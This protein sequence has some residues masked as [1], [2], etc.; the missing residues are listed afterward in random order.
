MPGGNLVRVAGRV[1]I[2][3]LAVAIFLAAKFFAT[4]QSVQH[5]TITQPGGLPGGPVLTGIEAITNGIRLTWD[6]PSGYYQVLR[7]SLNG[8]TWQAFGGRTNLVRFETIKG[9]LTNSIFTILGPSPKYAGATACAE[10]H[11]SIENTEVNTRHAHAYEVLTMAGQDKNASCLPCHTVGYGLTTGFKIVNNVV[12]TPQLKGVQCENCHSSAANHAANPDDLISRP[13]LE[14]AGQVCG[15]CHSG[16]QNPT[17]DEWK[18]SGHFQ[19]VEDM[20]DPSRIESCGRCHSGTSRLAQMAGLRGSALTNSVHGD[21]NVGITC[22]VCHEPHRVRVFTNVLNG[23]FA[24]TNSLTGRSI[25][26][27]NGELGRVY[28]NQLR[29][30]VASTKDFFLTTTDVLTNKYDANINACAQCH[31][32]RGASW[33]ITS[34]PPHHSPQYNMLLGT[35]GELDTGL[36]PNLPATH[37]RIEKQCASCHMQ[38]VAHQYGPPEIAGVTGH[39]FEVNSYAVCATCHNDAATAEGLVAF[40][41]LDTSYQIQIL[42]SWLDA[43]ALMKGPD[44]LRIKYGARAWEYTNPGD[45]SPGGSGPDDTE[46]AQIPV[47]IKKARYNLY[48]V[49]YDGSYGAHNGPFTIKLLETAQ[50]WVQAEVNN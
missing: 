50:D 23:V 22:V 38:T 28:T 48:L 24:F 15:G 46:Q 19:V 37:S 49:L 26:L 13:R 25:I 10:C 33:T 6:G 32:H 11:A 12:T 17:F 4:A 42:K 5:L 9:P 40:V 21:A 7:K 35:V 44:S 39:T 41:K 18:T 31:N 29:N 20:N 8:S 34:R 1:F 43:W 3:R 30:A 2:L 45:L 27:T 36:A 47:N 16:P 14:I